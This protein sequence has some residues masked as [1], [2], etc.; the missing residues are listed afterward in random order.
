MVTSPSI[1]TKRSVQSKDTKTE[2][3]CMLCDKGS[4]SRD[5]TSNRAV[6]PIRNM[7]SEVIFRPPAFFSIEN[8]SKTSV[9]KGGASINVEAHFQAFFLKPQSLSLVV[10][11][12]EQQS[13]TA[14]L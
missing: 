6:T 8:F 4:W 1:A 10:D 11:H 13:K 5:N 12:D 7:L 2:F 9:Q 14:R 3:G